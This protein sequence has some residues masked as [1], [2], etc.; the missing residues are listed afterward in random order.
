[1]LYCQANQDHFQCWQHCLKRQQ[2]EQ[3]I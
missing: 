1:M 2:P 3:Q